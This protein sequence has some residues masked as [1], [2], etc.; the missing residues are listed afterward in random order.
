M[1]IA[2]DQEKNY[3]LKTMINGYRYSYETMKLSDEYYR[4]IYTDIF[5][6]V[7]ERAEIAI[8]Y[9]E[10]NEIKGFILYNDDILHWIYTRKKYRH[11]GLGKQMLLDY[12]VHQKIRSFKISFLT[13]DFLTAFE[14]RIN[15]LYEPFLRY[16]Q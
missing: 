8:S 3:I 15:F 6:K 9:G 5:Q 7:C 14:N 4:K 16:E 12:L 10:N 11:K 1:S 2:K 13:K